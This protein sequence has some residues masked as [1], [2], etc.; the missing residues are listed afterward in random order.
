MD[1]RTREST[2]LKEEDESEMTSFGTMASA[3]D[4][5]EVVVSEDGAPCKRNTRRLQPR[6]ILLQR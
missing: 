1:W 6:V 5:V 3:V 4:E 2:S